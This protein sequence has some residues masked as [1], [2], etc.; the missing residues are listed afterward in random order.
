M[1]PIENRTLRVPGK[2]AQGKIKLWVDIMSMQD[3][4]NKPV[5]DISKP[6]SERWELRMVVYQARGLTVKD[7]LENMNDPF[8]IVSVEGANDDDSQTKIRDTQETDTHWRVQVR[9]CHA[10]HAHVD[11]VLSCAGAH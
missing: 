8:V 1:S 10:R 7:A 3:A 6:P 9:A 11:A 4:R 5:W 2:A